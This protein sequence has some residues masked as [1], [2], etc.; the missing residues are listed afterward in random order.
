MVEEGAVAPAVRP[1]PIA[2]D[3]QMALEVDRHVEADATDDL[4]ITSGLWVDDP[5]VG[6]TM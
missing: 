1:S 2:S 5:Q 6:L 3:A 4:D